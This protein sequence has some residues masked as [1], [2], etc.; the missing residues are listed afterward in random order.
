MKKSLDLINGAPGRSLLRF[1]L[2]MIIGNMFQQFYNM[3]DSIIVGNFVGED[4]LAAVGASYS[5][6]TVFI[7]IAIGGGIGASVLTSQYL[8]A[9]QYEKMKTSVHTFL[10]TFLAVSIVLA[11][12]GLIFNPTILKTVE[13]SRK[14][15]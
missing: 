5:F 14:Y 7:M 12:L 15:F 9:R 3:A 2:P 11:A 6:T 1:A 10:W 4:A 13:N 8:G